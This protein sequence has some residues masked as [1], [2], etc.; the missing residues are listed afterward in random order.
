MR[1]R[2]IDSGNL[3]SSGTSIRSATL[4]ILAVL[5]L[6]VPLSSVCFV[7]GQEL[8]KPPNAV[9]TGDP[10]GQVS[11]SKFRSWIVWAAPGV[12][13][14][15]PE[16]LNRFSG[17]IAFIDS[18]AFWD[19]REG[20]TR[21]VATQRAVGREFMVADYAPMA[22]R[23]RDRIMSERQARFKQ[24]LSRAAAPVMA[25]VMKALGEYAAAN[26]IDLVLDVAD[27]SDLLWHIP[28]SADLTGSFVTGFN[29]EAYAPQSVPTVRIAKIDPDAFFHRQNGLLPI[30]R[31]LQL[32]ENQ[33]R[34]GESVADHHERLLRGN[35]HLWTEIMTA[36]ADFGKQQSVILIDGSKVD[37]CEN[38]PDLTRDFINNFN[39]HFSS[40]SIE[41]EK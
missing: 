35:E 13:I 9:S 18:N 17:K 6:T 4:T 25:E 26:R 31:L 24:A 21:L 30:T 11:F 16:Q 33:R 2:L 7:S 37:F 20:I 39:L 15:D 8:T 41:P 27:S 32:P 38:C 28:P 1:L 40:R 29:G 19:E 12:D 3:F 14:Q 36:L 34:D 5:A 22:D 23:E 10:A